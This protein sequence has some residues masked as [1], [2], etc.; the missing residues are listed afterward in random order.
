MTVATN[1]SRREENHKEHTHK[2]HKLKVVPRHE[3]DVDKPSTTYIVYSALKGLARP[4]KLAS[5]IGIETQTKF[6]QDVLFK[7]HAIGAALDSIEGCKAVNPDEKITNFLAAKLRLENA[8]SVIDNIEN[9][10]PDAKKNLRRLINTNKTGVIKQLRRLGS[11]E[12]TDE[13]ANGAVHL[14]GT[15]KE[16]ISRKITEYTEQLVQY[17]TLTT[18]AAGSV[19]GSYFLGNH[20]D[21]TGH[22]I[23]RDICFDNIGL[24]FGGAAHMFLNFRKRLND[25]KAY[26]W[27]SKEEWIK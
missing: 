23:L 1:N 4:S 8:E 15:T 25:M 13:K 11:E 26:V 7:S 9:A 12:I 19:V 24:S 5:L 2:L 3:L 18:L 14:T 17:G 27:L 10:S 6:E 20:F 21:H 16:Y 22:S